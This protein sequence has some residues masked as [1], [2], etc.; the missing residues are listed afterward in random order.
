KKSRGVAGGASA[1]RAGRA[2]LMDLV[3]QHAS[4]GIRRC[5]RAVGVAPATY[6]RSRAPRR[7]RVPVARPTPARA[8]TPAEQQQVLGTMH[9]PRF[10]DLA[11]GQIYATLL[12]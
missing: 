6:Y 8:L 9:A 1:P 11:P 5:C 10:V 12:D 4:L 3:T 7:L 2:A